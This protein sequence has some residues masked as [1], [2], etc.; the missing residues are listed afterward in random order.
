MSRNFEKQMAKLYPKQKFQPKE[1]PFAMFKKDWYLR[2][3][4]E[5]AIYI[6]GFFC[7]L[8]KIFDITI[9]GRFP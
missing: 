2:S 5:K 7:I 1:S 4:F 8:W 6:L 9:L 3:W